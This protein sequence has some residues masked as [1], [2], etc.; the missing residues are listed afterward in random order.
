MTSGEGRAQRKAQVRGEILDAARA[1]FGRQGYDAV[2]M[3]EIARQIGY[4]ATAL[5]YHFPD[6]ES[7]YTSPA[8]Q[9]NHSLRPFSHT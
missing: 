6:K 5:Y 7:L 1:L 9:T 8:I 3:R 2:T 4:T